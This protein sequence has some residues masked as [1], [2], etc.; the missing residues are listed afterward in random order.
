MAYYD[1][2]PI[3]QGPYSKGYKSSCD[4]EL[5]MKTGDF[6]VVYGEPQANGFCMAEV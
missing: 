2:D 5:S 4:E 1:Y 3:K 6:V